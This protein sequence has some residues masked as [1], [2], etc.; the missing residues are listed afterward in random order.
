MI[1]EVAVK[2]NSKT[3]L[4]EKIVQES[5]VKYKLYT[6]DSAIDGKANKSVIAIVADYFKVPKKS[7]T[8]KLGNKSKIKL[9]EIAEN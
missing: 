6:T 8:I 2:P 4:L 7:V 9:I 1:I 5:V 3:N